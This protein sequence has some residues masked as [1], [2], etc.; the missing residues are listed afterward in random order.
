MYVDDIEGDNAHSQGSLA[1]NRTS[2]NQCGYLTVEEL[3]TWLLQMT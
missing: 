1:L 3:E 2:E